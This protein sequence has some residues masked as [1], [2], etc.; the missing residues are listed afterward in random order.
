MPEHTQAK[1]RVKNTNRAA[2]SDLESALEKRS[3]SYSFPNDIVELEHWMCF[4]INKP[5]LMKKDDFEITSDI[6]RIFLPLPA[7][8]ATGYN[9]GYS[10]E[11]L[12]PIGKEAA[13]LGEAFKTGGIESGLKSVK[14]KFSGLLTE[15]GL[16][17]AASTG[18]YYTTAAAEGGGGAIAG[19]VS[20]IPVVGVAIGATLAP[21][22]KGAMAGGGLA[23]NPYMALI[24]EA[25]NL[26]E[27]QFSWKFIAKD[28]NES[29]AI[30][31]IIK[32]FK[33]H[34]APQRGSGLTEHF[35]DYPDQFDIDFH[36]DANLYNI[37]PSVL[38]SMDV[39]YHAEGQ[40]LYFSI[41]DATED[42]ENL[43]IPV[44]IQLNVTFQEV[45]IVTRD[46]INEYNR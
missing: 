35:F 28:Y 10:S 22:A 40:P 17:K 26:R 18:L 3:L 45:A 39:N 23:R 9:Q 19:L 29:I 4:R 32:L 36:Y 15:E 33:Y 14:D 13:E 11:S 16:K 42:G 27:H 46:E 34:S 6:A 38:K 31:D 30:L 44:S 24:Y 1:L 37:G 12:G 2:V 41:D 20:K 25:P 8:L 7:Q 43:K 5:Q 21:A